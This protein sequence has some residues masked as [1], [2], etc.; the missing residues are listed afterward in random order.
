MGRVVLLVLAV[1]VGG[2]LA[3]S[4]AARSPAP[5]GFRLADGSAG[6]AYDGARLACR[7][8]SMTSAVV[9]EA[10]G[11]SS[12]GDVHVVWNDSTPILR[13]TESWWHEGFSCRVA[14]ADLVCDR[15]SGSIAVGPGGVGGAS[16]VETP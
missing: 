8:A 13:P 14:D 10:D 9:L 5:A 2:L 1:S 6:C 11:S 15:G 16:S 4:G 12:G 7:S 3:V